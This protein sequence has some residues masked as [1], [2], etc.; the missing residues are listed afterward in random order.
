MATKNSWNNT[1]TD[2]AITLN[3]TTNAINISSD[4]SATAVNVATGG[5]AKVCTIG[6]TS[7]ASSLALQYGTADFSIASASGT[8]MSALDTGE[9][10]YPLQS[11]FLAFNSVTDANQTGN[12]AAPTVEFNSEVFDQNGN[13]DNST[14]T[15]TA[16]VTGKYSLYSYVLLGNIVASVNCIMEIVTSNRTYSF[17]YLGAASIKDNLNQV[18]Q[19]I[20]QLCDMDTAD[21]AYVNVYSA[22]E[23]GNINSFIGHATIALTQFSGYLAC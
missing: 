5:A 19:K 4:A 22:A 21:T 11:A 1:I 2:A 13:Y 15:F 12:G 23:G 14:D 8:I 16:P 7:G 6:S 17:G 9:I 20:A 18:A 3:S 10:I